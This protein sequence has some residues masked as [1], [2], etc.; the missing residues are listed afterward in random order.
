MPVACIRDAHEVARIL[1]VMPLYLRRTD[2]SVNP[3]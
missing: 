2:Q 1:R 3:K